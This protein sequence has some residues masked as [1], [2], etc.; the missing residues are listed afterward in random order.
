MPVGCRGHLAILAASSCDGSCTRVHL[1]VIMLQKPGGAEGIHPSFSQVSHYLSYNA[2]QLLRMMTAMKIAFMLAV[3]CLAFL[4]AA[5]ARRLLDWDDCNR[6]K[7]TKSRKL[8][9][10]ELSI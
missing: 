2:A 7:S 4:T 8:C 10:G 3:V 5:D 9:R 1:H 6:G